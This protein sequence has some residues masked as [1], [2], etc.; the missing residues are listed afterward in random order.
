MVQHTCEHLQRS[1]RRFACRAA[2]AAWI[3]RVGYP[4]AT[5]FSL[6][7]LALVIGI[8]SNEWLWQIGLSSMPVRYLCALLMA[9]LVFLPLTGPV[10]ERWSRRVVEFGGVVLRDAHRRQVHDPDVKISE[11]SPDPPEID[12]DPDGDVIDPMSVPLLAVIVMSLTILGVCIYFFWVA[13]ALISEIVIEGGLATWLYRPVLRGP[14]PQWWIVA[15]ELTALPV[16]LI[17]LTL[18]AAGVCLHVYFPGS[19]SMVDVW[20]ALEIRRL[21]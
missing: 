12:N 7:S 1:S 14:N 3:A 4:R 15:L 16:A 5:V 13:P 20:H 8:A 9:Y 17:G 2:L 18:L 19:T 21:Y 11:E 10:A 6:L